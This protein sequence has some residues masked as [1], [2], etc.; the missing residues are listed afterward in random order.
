[1]AMHVCLAVFSRSV[2][3]FLKVL[4]LYLFLDPT[5]LRHDAVMALYESLISFFACM[6]VLIISH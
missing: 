1:M 3:S 5:F 2:N 6:G 4:V